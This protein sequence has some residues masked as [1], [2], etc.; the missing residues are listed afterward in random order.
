[1]IPRRS[2]RRLKPIWRRKTPTPGDARLDGAAAK[3][4]IRGDEGP[5][6]TGRLNRAGARRALRLL[7]PLRLRRPASGP[8]PSGRGGPTTGNRFC[9]TRTPKPRARPSSR[10][11]PLNTALTIHCS[12]T[13]WT[14][15]ARR[16]A[17][18]SSGIWIAARPFP[19]RSSP[20]PATSVGRRTHAGCSGSGATRRAAQ[21]GSIAAPHG[22][23]PPTTCWS[24]KKRTTASSWA[25]G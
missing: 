7:C 1:M 17:A 3:P 25:S 24:M 19:S 5:D 4:D 14:S 22:A 18:F 11:A 8:W 15:K 13:L 9:W 16:S 6:Q 21:P 2:S 20:A 23:G 10:W 12:L